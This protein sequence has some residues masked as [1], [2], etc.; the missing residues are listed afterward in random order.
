MTPH[1]RPVGHTTELRIS[2]EQV[3]LLIGQVAGTPIHTC[4]PLGPARLV[5]ECLRHAPPRSS[6]IERAIDLIEDALEGVRDQPPG[7]TL[8]TRDPALHDLIRRVLP[9]AAPEPHSATLDEVEQAFQRLAAVSLGYPAG[10]LALGATPGEAALLV[11]V[12][13]LMHHLGF[14]A[15]TGL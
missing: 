3:E 13:E 5:R 9:R 2:E 12:R 11:L 1:N 7:A 8:V 4:L 15:I 10:D 14:T 6:D